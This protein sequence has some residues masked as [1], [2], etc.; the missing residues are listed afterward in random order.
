MWKDLMIAVVAGG[1]GYII[2]R[3]G[4]D[5]AEQY[6]PHMVPMK[7]IVA[8]ALMAAAVVAISDKMIR[9]P[10]ARVSAQAAAAIPLVE[11][12]VNRAG[13]GHMLGTQKVLMLPPPTSTPA[14][15]SAQLNARLEANLEDEYSS[16]Y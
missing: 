14:A 16:E 4:S 5:L 8:P 13:L 2:A 3:K 12:I 1:A 9:D 11:A 7:D 15:L 10:K 6:L